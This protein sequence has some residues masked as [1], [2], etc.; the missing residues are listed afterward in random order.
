MTMA[1]VMFLLTSIARW[2]FRPMATTPA[3]L[4]QSVR[5]TA[6]GNTYGQSDVPSDL[7]SAVAISA[8]EYHTCALESGGAVRCWGYNGYD[9]GDVPS[10]L[11]SAVAISAGGYYTCAI[12]VEGSVRCW[13]T[14]AMTP[15]MCLLTL[16]AR[17]LF[18]RVSTIPAR[19]SLAVPCGAGEAIAMAKLMSLLTLAARWL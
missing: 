5:F 19:L 7:G 12:D 9:A 6:G 4:I 8:G 14:M 3:R 15:G 2:R 1:K 17:W 13:G 18:R 16:I 11:D 10:D